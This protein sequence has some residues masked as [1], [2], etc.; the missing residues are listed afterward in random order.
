M[1]IDQLSHS[2]EE[3]LKYWLTVLAIFFKK[4]RIPP[5]LKAMGN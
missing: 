5:Y 2:F 3:F 4:R 1:L